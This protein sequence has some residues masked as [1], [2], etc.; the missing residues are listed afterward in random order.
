[1]LLFV[2]PEFEVFAA[3]FVF[4]LVFEVFVLVGEATAG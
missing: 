2:V 3:L 1:M 4:V